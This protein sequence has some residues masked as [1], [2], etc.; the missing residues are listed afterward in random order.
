MRRNFK[1]ATKKKIPLKKESFSFKRMKR[2]QYKNLGLKNKN[3]Y[4]LFP[5]EFYTN[6]T[7][8]QTFIMIMTRKSFL[9][10][11]QEVIRPY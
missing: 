5:L 1:R 11:I 10:H 7:F 8:S 2:F 9:S 3:E 6:Q 4:Y